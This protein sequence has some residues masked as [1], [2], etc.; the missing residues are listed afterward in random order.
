MATLKLAIKAATRE[1]GQPQW[2]AQMS[3]PAVHVMGGEL[4]GTQQSWCGWWGA[5]ILRPLKRLDAPI[6][7]TKK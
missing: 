5:E 7:M 4:L 2:R 3:Q 1:P 6:D